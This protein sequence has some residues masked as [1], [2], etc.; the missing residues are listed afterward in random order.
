M[1]P[2]W[3]DVFRQ[4]TQIARD[5]G[6]DV[7]IA[8]SP[9]W[10]QTGGVWVAPRDA[11]KKYV[12]SELQVDGG[13]PFAGVLPKPPAATGP[14]LGAKVSRRGA[15]PVQL[16]GDLYEDSLVI[17]Y[18][19]PAA[20]VAAPAAYSSSAGAIDLAPLAAGDLAGS[21]SLPLG[22]GQTAWVQAAFARPTLAR[23]GDAR[24]A[25]T[26]R[27]RGAG[28]RRRGDLPHL[29]QVS[30]RTRRDRLASA[31]LRHPRD[32]REGVPGDP[33]GRP[34]QAAAS[35][36]AGVHVRAHTAARGAGDQQAR[37]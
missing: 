2:G 27:R 1:S 28:Q 23:G 31:D 25:R 26:G 3:R 24:R 16:K 21:V 32:D 6:M 17:A 30:R 29:G 35:K 20:E 8:G 5:T 33:Y 34:A 9:G 15:G 11:M 18:P 19:T 7:T 10:S 37:L 36:P 4:T 13:K 14:F 12:W 22:A